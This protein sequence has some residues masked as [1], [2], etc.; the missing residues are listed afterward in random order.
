MTGY[1][2]FTRDELIDIFNNAECK[3]K[4]GGEAI[5]EAVLTRVLRSQAGTIG[6][7]DLQA[8]NAAIARAQELY[9]DPDREQLAQQVNDW[10]TD[11]YGDG[12]ID[13]DATVK[14]MG[15]LRQYFAKGTE[16]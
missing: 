5:Q 7:I 1:V 11:E 12:D 8:A 15:Q 6:P 13:L 14:L 4:D 10:F 3:R 2:P 16:Q 9:P